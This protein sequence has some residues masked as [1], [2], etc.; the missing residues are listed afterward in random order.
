M[1][2]ETKNDKVD[3]INHDKTDNQRSN[4]R[5]CDDTLNAHNRSSDGYRG[6]YGTKRTGKRRETW[7]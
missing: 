5:I 2:P 6:I 1:K 4:L 3:H 7:A